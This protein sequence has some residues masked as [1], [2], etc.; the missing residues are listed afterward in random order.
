MI[1]TPTTTLLLAQPK[2]NPNDSPNPNPNPNPEPNS[3]PNHYPNP[4][5]NPYPY[6]DPNPDPDP[7]LN[8]NPKAAWWFRRALLLFP[9]ARFIAKVARSS[10]SSRSRR[11]G[12]MSSK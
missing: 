1:L 9:R 11:K 8:P 4:Y 10:S 5:P 7:N 2:P 12:S 3:Y 6:P